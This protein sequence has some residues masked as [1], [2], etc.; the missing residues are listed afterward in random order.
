MLEEAMIELVSE[1]VV[2][3]G[4]TVDPGAQVAI[5]PPRGGLGTVAA[6]ILLGGGLRPSPLAKHCPCS[7][8]DLMV[9]PGVSVLQAWCGALAGLGRDAVLPVTVALDAQGALPV[10]AAFQGSVQLAI[11]R[12]ASPFRG[13]AGALRDRVSQLD[14]DAIVLVGE[15]ARCVNADLEVMVARHIQQNHDVTVACNSDGSPAGIYVLR[16]RTL[17]HVPA[18]GFMDLK[19]QWLAA[20]GAGRGRVVVHRWDAGDAHPLRTREQFLEAVL[21][22]DAAGMGSSLISRTA[23]VAEGAFVSRSVVMRSACVASGAVVVRSLV[24]PGAHVAAGDVVV[25]GIIGT[26][27]RRELS[28]GPPASHASPSILFRGWRRSRSVEFG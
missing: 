10:T 19:E 6:C 7:V 11:D 22:R 18:I 13:P 28:E 9:R 21:P 25:D 12:D 14:P 16:R 26:A 24:L 27:V 1:R 20:V 5:P 4:S 8:L 15:S 17:D 3:G 2:G 23:E